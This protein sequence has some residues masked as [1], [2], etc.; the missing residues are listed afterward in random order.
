MSVEDFRFNPV[1]VTVDAGTVVRWFQTGA[2]DHTVTA[3]DGSFNSHPACPPVCM[4]QNGTFE[5]RF[6]QAGTFRYYCKI[7]GEPGGQGM[8]GRVVVRPAPTSPTTTAAAPAA[9]SGPKSTVSSGATAPPVVAGAAVPAAGDA[10]SPGPP[11]ARAVSEAS[12]PAPRAAGD[13]SLPATGS[14]AGA[15]SIALV[16]TALAAVARRLVPSSRA[17]P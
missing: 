9:S 5:H 12:T 8:S 14:R 10:T 1:E 17:S 7:H 13:S 6:S 11:G 4:K 16:V 2:A 15:L 3:D